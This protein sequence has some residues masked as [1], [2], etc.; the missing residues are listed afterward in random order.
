MGPGAGNTPASAHSCQTRHTACVNGFFKKT[1]W[2][3]L[4]DKRPGVGRRARGHGSSGGEAE[5]D[6]CT[7]P[8]WTS[9]ELG[10]AGLGWAVWTSDVPGSYFQ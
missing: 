9:P 5:G 4:H 7:L 6:K 2:P 3:Y 1:K 8:Q 10:W